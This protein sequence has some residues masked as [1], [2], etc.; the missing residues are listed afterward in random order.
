MQ[1]EG[2]NA[3]ITGAGSGLGAEIARVFASEG[4]CVFATDINGE[5]AERV[6]EQC[7]RSTDGSHAAVCD[8]SDSSSVAQAFA[9]FDDRIGG[10]DILVNNAGI[11]HREKDYVRR[12]NETGSA[13]VAEMMS[14]TGIQTHWDV[15]ENLSDEQFDRM[16]RTYLYGTFYCTREAL[17]RMRRG[18]R[19]GRI[20]NMGS[21]MGS[22]SLAGAPDYCAAKGA[23]LAFT[24][25][26]AREAASYGV[27]ANAIAPGF[28]DT[29]LLS[30]VRPETRTLFTMQTPQA[31]LGQPNEVASVAL[32]LAGSGSS[33][34]TGQVVSPNGG[35]YM[36]Q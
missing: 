5:S 27:L 32:F 14:G 15:I 31:R 22:A 30:D 6:A 21:I 12:V 4:A 36:A 18:G 9:A 11:V 33:F 19:G 20:I 23:I 35:I 7:R 17:G 28:I 8:V 13:Q 25:A 29:P 3:F 24:R 34:M 26:T 16:L 10:L 1:L 2:K